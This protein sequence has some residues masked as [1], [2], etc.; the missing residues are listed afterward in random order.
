[1]IQGTFIDKASDV[2]L[3]VRVYHDRSDTG[4]VPMIET[5]PT[6]EGFTDN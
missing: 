2:D 1:M 4:G 3:T 6:T 5:I